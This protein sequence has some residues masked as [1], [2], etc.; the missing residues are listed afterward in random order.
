[1]CVVP[2]EA[3]AIVEAAGEYFNTEDYDRLNHL[4]SS[5]MT[6]HAVAPK[7]ARAG[8]RSGAPSPPAWLA[9]RQ[10]HSIPVDGDRVTVHM[11]SHSTHREPAI[12]LL[13]AISPTGKR[14]RWKFIH[15]LGVSRRD[16]LSSTSPCATIPGC[17]VSYTAQALQKA[18][19]ASP[20]LTPSRTEGL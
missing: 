9:H 2:E 19:Q 8:S 17:T 12:A 4:V 6:N 13:T 14:I 18:C 7:G 5:E 15:L 11:T 3:R 10:T 20:V 16:R 1:V